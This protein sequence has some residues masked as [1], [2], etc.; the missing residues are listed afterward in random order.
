MNIPDEE[1]DRLFRAAN[2]ST[3]RADGL[4]AQ[5]IAVRENII[6]GTHAPA[7]ERQGW[8]WGRLAVAVTAIIA[9]VVIATNALA[10]TQQAVALTPPP[11][12]FVNPQPLAAVVQEA[13]EHL[14]SGASVEQER[15]VSSLVWGWDIDLAKK[16]V[17]SV[18][19]IVTF[20][21]SPE[22]GSRSTI[23]AGEPF[24]PDGVRPEG[25]EPSPYQPGETI[26]ELVTAPEDLK[27]PAD[28]VSLRDGSRE[29]V[30][31]ALISLG[32]TASA[33]SGEIL[34]VIGRLLSYWTLTDEQHAVL[35]DRLIDAG[36][37]AV[38]GESTDRLGRGVVGLRVSDPTTTYQDT[39]LISRDTGR[40]V[41]I[42]NELTVAQDFIPAGVVGYTLWDIG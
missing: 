13:Q 15:S 38:L 41:G 5:A 34:V 40:I 42:E 36:S 1:I 18:P 24:W 3:T 37:V 4:T 28:V 19:Q 7:R 9:V 30:E 16:R 20:E 31:R 8:A 32:A 17:E 22:T 2:P 14:E 6:R 26:T 23:V 33:S 21:W 29:S 27:I 10:P 35:I 25:I 39:V 12:R 11:L